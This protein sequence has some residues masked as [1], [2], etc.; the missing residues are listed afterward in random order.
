M[1]AD[2][3][4]SVI[5]DRAV[6]WHA[7]R[8]HAEAIRSQRATFECLVEKAWWVRP[9][10]GGGGEKPDPCWKQFDPRAVMYDGYGNCE[11]DGRMDPSEYCAP[12]AERE[13]LRPAFKAAM[14]KR[15]AAERAFWAA[16]KGRSA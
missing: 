10:E 1:A 8:V 6:R 11:D 7:A 12:C 2:M 14:A 16:V 5:A 9:P 4:D 15:G 13:K 3:T